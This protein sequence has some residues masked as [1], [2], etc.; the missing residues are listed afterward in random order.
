MSSLSLEIEECRVLD[1]FEVTSRWRWRRSKKAL[2]F[3]RE[4]CCNAQRLVY[5]GKSTVGRE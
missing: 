2:A 4:I 5:D 3:Q 1:P